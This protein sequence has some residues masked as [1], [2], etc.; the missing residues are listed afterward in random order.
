MNTTNV[1]ED[2]YNKMKNS[3]TVVNDSSEYTLGDY[4]LMKAGAKAESS[5]LPALRSSSSGD[6]V[7]S[8]FFKFVNEKLTLKSAPAKDKTIRRF[9]FRTSL[10]AVFSALIA[11]T[12]IVSYGV[13]ALR[14][15]AN[16][17]PS[18]VEITETVDEETNERYINEN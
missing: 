11:C 2:L 7:V 18:T 13:F 15:Q 17:V 16:S 5:S 10:A 6:M 4:M 8:T 9:P 12:L 14:G 1:Y 3:F